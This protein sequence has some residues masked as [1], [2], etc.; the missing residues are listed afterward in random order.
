MP[1]TDDCAPTHPLE[2]TSII[3]N[4]QSHPGIL[5]PFGVI[6]PDDPLVQEQAFQV[7][8]SQG[9]HGV[10]IRQGTVLPWVISPI[11]RGSIDAITSVPHTTGVPSDTTGAA[12]AYICLSF[13][14][15]LCDLGLR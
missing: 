11:L 2:S 13:G 6:A 1:G 10:Q 5:V 7:Q 8:S 9:D 14:R 3:P 12:G 4:D 15:I